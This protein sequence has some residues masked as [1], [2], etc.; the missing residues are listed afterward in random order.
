MGRTE[1]NNG[2]ALCLLKVAAEEEAKRFK[3]K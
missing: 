3:Y 2:R 1:V